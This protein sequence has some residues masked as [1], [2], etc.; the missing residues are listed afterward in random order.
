[1][2]FS[3]LITFSYFASFALAGADCEAPSSDP[4]DMVLSS[5]VAADEATTGYFVNH[6]FLHVYNLA[7]SIKFYS[8][9][10][11]MRHVF[12]VNMTEHVSL[13]YMSHSQG[14]RNGSAYQTTKE[15]LR[16]KNNNAGHISFIHLNTKK[17]RIPGSPERTSTLNHIGIVVPDLKA[18]QSR[19]EHL[20]VT[21]HKRI[22]E[23]MRTS[24]H[25]SEKSSLGDASNL[26]DEG[27][28]Q[29]QA[30]IG[31]FARQ[32]IYAADPDGNQLEILPLNEANLFS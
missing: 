29:L 1:M 21:I 14:G 26:S 11:G 30:F 16:Y 22:D 27:F 7:Q 32:A 13:T 15:I 19:L 12:T 8:E 6:I 3:K 31:Q 5:D 2:R 4:I 9:A 24:G 25:V 18:T 10:F 23:A 20:G 17:E 28:A